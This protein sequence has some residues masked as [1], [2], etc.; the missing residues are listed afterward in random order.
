MGG[1]PTPAELLRIIDRA[2]EDKRRREAL[3]LHWKIIAESIPEVNDWP[4][5]GGRT[6]MASTHADDC[7]V[8][9]GEQI[10]RGR[11]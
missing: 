5:T 8:S 1:T 3:D 2:R 9:V 7:V 10:G 11:T 6:C 4:C